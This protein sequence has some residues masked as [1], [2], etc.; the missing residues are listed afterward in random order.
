MKPLSRLS[1]YLSISSKKPIL[2]NVLINLKNNLLVF[3]VTNLNIEMNF[4]VNLSCNQVIRSGLTTVNIHKLYDLCKTFLDSSNLLFFLFNKRLRISCLNSKFYLSTLPVDDFPIFDRK[5]KYK[6][7][8]SINI[9]LFKKII[10]AIYFSISDQDVHFYL[11]GMLFDYRINFFTVTTDSYRMSIYKLPFD[12]IFLDNIK[13]NFSFILPKKLVLELSRFLNII[14]NKKK[15]FLFVGS[16][17]VKIFFSKFKIYSNLIDGTFPDYKYILSSTKQYCYIDLDFLNFKN[18]II[19]SSVVMDNTYNYVTFYIKKNLFKVV[20]NNFYNDEVIEKLIISY[21]GRSL[22][23]SFNV[24]YIL[25]IVCSIKKS[26]LI[27]F[28]FRD[29]LSIA[30]FVDLNNKFV[31]YMV[32]PVKL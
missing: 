32:M 29:K 2:S 13:N 22:E 31:N 17:K 26:S 15:I 14:D 7:K 11:N 12:D 8:L 25:D 4:F 20:S 10:D 19:R 5:F 21:N 23:I 24:K 9:E 1:S 27:R 30:K 28:F 16:N 6:Y 3:T 18:S